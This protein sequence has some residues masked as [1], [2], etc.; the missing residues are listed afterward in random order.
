M[1]GTHLFE[2]VIAMFLAII[3]LHYIAHRLGL[4]PS[5]ALLAGGG[6]LAFVPGLP[7]IS[8]NPELV[9]VIF[10]PPLLLDG[11]WSISVDRLKRHVF[12]IASLAIGAVLFTTVIVAV[13]VHF[14]MPSLPWAACAALGA[15]VSPP[16]AV[17]ARAVLERIRIP[18]R[19]QILLEGESLLNDASGLVLFRFAVAAAAGGVFS[20]VD[21]LGEFFFLAVGGA[22]V[23]AFVGLLWV[24]TVRHLGDE[25]LMIAATAV[26][27]WAAYILAEQAQTSGVIATVTAGLIASWHQHTVLSAATRMRGTSFWNVLVFL[28][29]AMVFI[30]IG[31]SL[32]DVVERGGGFGSIASSMA[33]PALAVLVTLV[34]ARFVWI[35]ASDLV[36]RL[37]HGLKLAHSK[38]LGPGAVTALG[39]AG[40]RGVVTLA[41]A[42]SL[43]ED[44]PGR[45]FILVMAFAV[46]M[47]TVLIQGTTL[48]RIIAWAGLGGIE[49]ERA[50]MTMSEAEA[51]MAQVQFTTVQGLAYDENGELI[52]PQLLKRY[53]HRLAA[54][55]KYAESTEKY[56]P[57]LHAHFDVVLK[58]VAAGRKELIRL[59][60]EGQI[61]D[62]TL[63]ELEHDLDLEE[64]T[65]ISA[66]A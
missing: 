43:P 47:G 46:I 3:V 6:T 25:Y 54:S 11:A 12:G 57:L 15:I 56:S 21:A 62:E 58:A 53:E 61:D 13:V 66:K 27:S 44:F 23:G 65:A 18:R 26:L 2:L 31:L 48:G 22:A 60:R 1:D 8:V 7:T 50:P 52:H 40:M 4:P 17:S 64:L 38:P 45:D 55:V 42:L 29:E 20:T 16:D 5:V 59:R 30:L 37:F 32:R 49:P 9:L 33:L 14:L 39:W 35:F 41:L 34:A 63:R 36:I 19:L 28:M 24:K 10:L 51:S